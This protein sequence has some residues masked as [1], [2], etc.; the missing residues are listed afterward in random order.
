[1]LEIINLVWRLAPLACKTKAKQEIL[2]M[3]PAEL[4]VGGTF[5]K[6]FLVITQVHWLN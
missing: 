5:R 6:A 3:S 2:R 4:L 1:M